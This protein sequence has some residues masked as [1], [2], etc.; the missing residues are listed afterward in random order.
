MNDWLYSKNDKVKLML[1]NFQRWKA[2]CAGGLAIE[3]MCTGIS[4]L[5]IKNYHPFIS[6]VLKIFHYK[7]FY[8]AMVD[9]A[10]LSTPLQMAL[11]DKTFLYIFPLSLLTLPPHTLLC[12]SSYTAI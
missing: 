6:L 2:V 7:L 10:S 12:Q 8:A 4:N 3:R 11:S 5:N 9:V 1:N